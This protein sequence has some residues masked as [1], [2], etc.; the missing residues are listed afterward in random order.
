M[1][2]LFLLIKKIGIKPAFYKIKRRIFV[3]DKDIISQIA[4]VGA[5]DYLIRYQYA[6]NLLDD[7]KKNKDEMNPYPNKIW[8]CWFQGVDNAPEIILKCLNSI[9]KYH[10]EDVIILTDDNIPTYLDIPDY[11]TRKRKNG[12]IS[13]THYSDIVRYMIIEKY[14]G[15]WLDGTTWLFDI[16]PNYIRNADLFLFRVSGASI[17]SMGVIAAKPY[18]EIISRAKRIILK[19]WEKENKLISYTVTAMCFKLAINSTK[20]TLAAWENVINVPITKNLL[21]GALFK[22]FNPVYLDIIKQQCVIQQL[23]WKF[24]KEDYEKKGTFYDVVVRNND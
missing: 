22:D 17:A 6:A 23:S 1:K 4:L 19:Y 7:N 8:T 2:K 16:V 11:I 9:K 13:N 12:I 15:V 21:I 3:K 10:K 18:N 14:G 5:Y 24:P 20:E